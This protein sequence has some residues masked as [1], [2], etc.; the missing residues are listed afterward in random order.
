MKYSYDVDKL[1]EIV[2][3][4]SIITGVRIMIVDESNNEICR[5]S[6]KRAPFCRRMLL[7]PQ[8]QEKCRT[9]ETKAVYK[10]SAKSFVSASCHAG[11]TESSHPI[12][13]DGEFIGHI[14][15]GP[16]RTKENIYDF[17][18]NL[19]YP[20]EDMEKLNEVYRQTPYY[21][22]EK[23]RAV[24]RIVAML[25]TYIISNEYIN[26]ETSDFMRTVSK[27]I[28]DNLTKPLNAEIICRELNVSKTFLY[29]QF[30][31]HKNMTVNEYINSKRIVKAK[32]NL[33]NS[34]YPIS[35]ISDEVGIGD[36]TYF[37]KIFKKMT[38]Y[39]PLQYRKLFKE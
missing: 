28:T 32:Y 16:M 13:K 21:D 34:N 35:K 18:D 1:T 23:A 11:F 7:N 19:N 20:V 5:S 25:A 31:I 39:T 33:V 17:V 38:G 2:N 15:F 4:Y 3:D 8:S 22:D 30:R 10:R 6:Y 27:Y 9:S 14:I 36:Y 26:T 12:I 24:G 29:N 37:S